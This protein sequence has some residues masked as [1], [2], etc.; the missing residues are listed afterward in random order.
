MPEKY[1]VEY[2]IKFYMDI[3]K[4]LKTKTIIPILKKNGYKKVG[5]GWF[6]FTEVGIVYVIEINI[7]AIVKNDFS[8]TLYNGI[9]F[10]GVM[11]LCYGFPF[12]VKHGIGGCIYKGG[13]KKKEINQ[14]W[15]SDD[16]TEVSVFSESI[17]ESLENKIIPFIESIQ[18][19]E[20]LL[21]LFQEDISYY[22]KNDSI[23]A[24]QIACLNFLLGNKEKGK[25][26]VMMAIRNSKA[27]YEFAEQLLNRMETL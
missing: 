12:N 22:L 5:I 27:K 11:D 13:M 19:G 21:A 14:Y 15:N 3:A 17:K 9:Y 8:L 26:I 20:Q 25:E 24:L 1:Y 18:N 6:K 4:E 7:S 23:L 16:F 10:E 2:T